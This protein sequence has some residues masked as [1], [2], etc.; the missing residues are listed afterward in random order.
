MLKYKTEKVIEVQD[1][2]ALVTEVY[3]RPYSFQQQD[4][5]KSRGI[6]YLEVPYDDDDDDYEDDIPEEVNGIEMG[7]SFE[8]WKSRDPLAPVGSSHDQFDIKLFWYRNFYPSIFKVANDL[9]AKGKIE[10]GSYIIK[11]DW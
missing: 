8:V 3:G 9:L 1:W 2:D 7:V 5:C 4:G 11:I 10:A 6:F